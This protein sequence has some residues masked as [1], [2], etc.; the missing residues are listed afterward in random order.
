MNDIV[1]DRRGE[2]FANEPSN[3]GATA[4]S[5]EPTGNVEVPRRTGTLK[6]SIMS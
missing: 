2:I 6:K 3:P 4:S 1:L 5:M